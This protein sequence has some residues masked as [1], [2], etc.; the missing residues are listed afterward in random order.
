MDADHEPLFVD[1]SYRKDHASAIESDSDPDWEWLERIQLA[2]LDDDAPAF[3]EMMNNIPSDVDRLEEETGLDKIW[4]NMSKWDSA[5]CALAVVDGQLEK[6][7]THSW[8]ADLG[9]NDDAPLHHFVANDAFKTTALLL[10]I[11]FSADVRR[12]FCYYDLLKS[13]RERDVLPIHVILTS[14]RDKIMFRT[15]EE[16]SAIDLVFHL[17]VLEYRGSLETLRVVAPKTREVKREFFNYLNQGKM[18]EVGA[19][20]LVAKSCILSSSTSTTATGE[21]EFRSISEIR[22]FVLNTKKNKSETLVLLDILEKSGDKLAKLLRLDFTQTPFESY[23]SMRLVASLTEDAGYDGTKQF[24]DLTF[25]RRNRTES[26]KRVYK[27][28]MDKCDM[29]MRTSDKWPS[30]VKEAALRGFGDKSGRTYRLAYP[31]LGGTLQPYVIRVPV[32]PLLT[33]PIYEIPMPANLTGVH[34]LLKKTAPY[35][36]KMKRMFRRG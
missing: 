31:F 24:N 26:E 15:K 3:V 4:P 34:H 17:C 2:L 11:G 9:D 7:L 5:K 14:L 6:Y 28:L 29:T 32:P 21:G 33:P 1:V 36:G 30:W 35:S 20:L 8:F 18:I 10:Q 13:L 25:T 22:D 23:C 12:N 27:R 16:P 19:L